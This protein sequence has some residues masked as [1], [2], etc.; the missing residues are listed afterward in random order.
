MQFRTAT[1]G[2]AADTTPWAHSSTCTKQVEGTDANV[3]LLH[4]LMITKGTCAVT[5]IVASVQ[6]STINPNDAAASRCVSPTTTLRFVAPETSFRFD[7]SIET[8]LAATIAS[9]PSALPTACNARWKSPAK[10]AVR[11]S[12]LLADAAAA[13]AERLLPAPAPAAAADEDD[14]DGDNATAASAAALDPGAAAS[15]V[16]RTG[17]GTGSSGKA[18]S[19]NKVAATARLSSGAVEEEE[20]GEER[21]TAVRAK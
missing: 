8:V 13:R 21:A 6:S 5:K 4:R 17:F 9:L 20:E 14:D 2:A 16:D 19:A 1:S 12:S 11:R 18:A 10:K 15:A 7:K 3:V